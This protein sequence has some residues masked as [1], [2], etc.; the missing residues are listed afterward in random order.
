MSRSGTS[1]LVVAL[2]VATIFVIDFAFLRHRFGV[3]LLVNV[4]IVLVVLG[5]YWRF[6][7]R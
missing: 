5:L 4:G 6:I 3:R 7:R 2:M 1:A